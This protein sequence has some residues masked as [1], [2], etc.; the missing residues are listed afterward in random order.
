MSS[1]PP[2][3]RL[4]VRFASDAGI[5]VVIR[6][7]PSEWCQLIVWDLKTNEFTRG[8]WV[9]GLVRSASLSPNGEHLALQIQGKGR[10][11]NHYSLVSRPPYF[12]ALA[13]DF[14]PASYTTIA[15]TKNGELIWTNHVPIEFR[16]ANEC[17]YKVVHR[18]LKFDELP[19]GSGLPRIHWEEYQDS[20]E[21]DTPGG[22]QIL[23]R[24]GMIYEKL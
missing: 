17:P 13:I 9:H 15:F 16:V 5:A 4:A 22:R 2:P 6:R 12:T 23:V 21:L 14:G 10:D 3:A 24:E 7:G 1:P 19:R 20:H 8:Q 18:D 11:Y